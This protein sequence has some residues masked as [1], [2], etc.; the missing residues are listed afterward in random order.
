MVSTGLRTIQELIDEEKNNIPEGLY[1]KL[2]NALQSAHEDDTDGLY[3]VRYVVIDMALQ[4]HF[5]SAICE[6]SHD[7]S[8]SSDPDRWY[9]AIH[10]SMLTADML[11]ECMPSIHKVASP[12]CSL[13]LIISAESR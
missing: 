6:E 13:L 4:F 1:L 5:Y 7:P 8:L 9:K 2:M 12:G 11:E 10:N 3:D